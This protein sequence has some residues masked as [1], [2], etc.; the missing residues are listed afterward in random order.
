M[1]IIEVVAQVK[2]AE[3]QTKKLQAEACS[4]EIMAK[5]VLLRERRKLLDEN[6]SIQDV[7]DFFLINILAFDF[8]DCYPLRFQEYVDL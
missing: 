4:A 2:V 7:D 8:F 5:V 6:F 3:A 1:R